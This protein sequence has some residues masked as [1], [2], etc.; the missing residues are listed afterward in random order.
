[1]FA[2]SS[3]FFSGAAVDLHGGRQIKSL[4]EWTTQ[5]RICLIIKI[6]PTSI[7]ATVSTSLQSGRL[8]IR[9]FILEWTDDG[10]GLLFGS[11]FLLYSLGI[12]IA[13]IQ[14]SRRTKA[15]SN[16]IIMHLL[17]TLLPAAGLKLTEP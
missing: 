10:P 9:S 8:S 17:W 16:F 6:R 13:I 11:I 14:F 12:D 1:M 7:M 2:E 4:R 3:S 15:P 5:F